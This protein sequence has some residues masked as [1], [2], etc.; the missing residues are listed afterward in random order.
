M[1]PLS[2]EEFDKMIAGDSSSDQ[3]REAARLGDW[4]LQQLKAKRLAAY[5]PLGNAHGLVL[6]TCSDF[7]GILLSDIE[8]LTGTRFKVRTSTKTSVQ[9]QCGVTKKKAPVLS[10]VLCVSKL[11]E[12]E[13]QLKLYSET[14]SNGNLVDTDFLQTFMGRVSKPK[15]QHSH[16]APERQFEGK[17]STRATVLTENCQVCVVQETVKSSVLR[18]LVLPSLSDEDTVEVL[19]LNLE[20]CHSVD[21]HDNLRSLTLHPRL[22]EKAVELVSIE[23]LKPAKI[24]EQVSLIAS[25]LIAAYRKLGIPGVDSGLNRRFK[26]TPIDV[27]NIKRSH[28]PGEFRL[29]GNDQVSLDPSGKFAYRPYSSSN[30][31][32]AYVQSSYATERFTMEVRDF[33]CVT[34]ALDSTHNTNHYKLPCFNICTQTRNG[35]TLPIAHFVVGSLRAEDIEQGLQVFA[36]MN[37]D[38]IAQLKYIMIDHD[39]AERSAINR[40]LPK[41]KVLYCWFHTKQLLVKHLRDSSSNMNPSDQKKAVDLFDVWLK[42]VDSNVA[43]NEQKMTQFLTDHRSAVISV[44]FEEITRKRTQLVRG[45]RLD[46]NFNTTNCCEVFHSL[47]KYGHFGAVQNK[48]LSVLIG[49]LAVKVPPAVERRITNADLKVC[50]KVPPRSRIVD[51]SLFVMIDYTDVVVQCKSRSDNAVF[52]TVHVLHGSCTCSGFVLRDMCDHIESATSYFLPR[53]L[54]FSTRS[55]P[56]LHD[57]ET[58]STVQ[59]Q[60]RSR[61]NERLSDDGADDL[62]LLPLVQELPTIQEMAYTELLDR[63]RAIKTAA[64]TLERRFTGIDPNIALR[65]RNSGAVA[66]LESA[67]NGLQL[68]D[69]MIP[70]LAEY[71]LPSRIVTQSGKPTVR[72]SRSVRTQRDPPPLRDVSS[73]DQGDDFVQPLPLPILQKKRSLPP[74]REATAATV[75][76]DAKRYRLEDSTLD[77]PGAAFSKRAGELKLNVFLQKLAQLLETGK[78]IQWSSGGSCIQL[79]KN[80]TSSSNDE[81]VVILREAFGPKTGWHSVQSQLNAYGFEKA[82]NDDVTWKHECWNVWQPHLALQ[83]V[84]TQANGR[85]ASQA[86]LPTVEQYFTSRQ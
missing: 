57:I 69:H 16:H 50:F 74:H 12:N 24:I 30:G 21:C 13:K 61:A 86:E 82:A 36:D 72:R 7:A 79:R 22:F 75:R 5:A 49:T 17:R 8:I 78:A 33:K 27:D 29:A 48:L 34:I 53:D 40:V 47:L 54:F 42:S 18:S 26:L 19:A 1:E 45:G 63:I 41:L 73:E 2:N 62:E 35:Q 38:L 68:F 85:P 39:D 20:H 55:E 83:I 31:I 70:A 4:C 3:S 56:Q 46:A 65:M 84:R 59:Q 9:Y 23:S 60:V 66:H 71:D 58:T 64:I 25:D 11:L 51:R 37:A 6:V 81:Y 76:E 28:A 52:H 32:L 44:W 10:P 43:S 67:T 15:S 77:L 80:Q 14:H